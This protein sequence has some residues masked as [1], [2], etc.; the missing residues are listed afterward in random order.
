MQSLQQRKS[1]L[2]KA[3]ILTAA[4]EEF[5]DKGF[6]GARIDEIAERASVNKRMIYEHFG[7]KD[8]LYET[9]LMSVYER[10]A[11]Y[12]RS[13]IIEDLEP[14]L[15][16]RHIINKYF[17]FLEENP[18]FV[19]MLMWE[20]LNNA[21]GIRKERA[22]DLKNPI[23][24][25]ITRQVKRGK[26]LGIFKQTVD[27]YQIVVSTMNFVFSYFS[28]MYTLSAIFERDMTA[29]AEIIRRADF[30]SGLIIDYL[31]V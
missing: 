4:E 14:V 7:N 18:S 26:E 28:N 23:F 31:L 3:K 29:P 17:T 25:Y 24:S 30:V 20:N 13:L 16:L 19:R 27:E 8:G 11:S 15:A 21:R 12:E 22:K 9:V 2:T 5:C 6:F 10:I 1:E